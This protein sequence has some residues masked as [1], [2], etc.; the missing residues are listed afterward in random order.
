[1]DSKCNADCKFCVAALRYENRR[2][3]YQKPCLD[4]DAEYYAR[5]RK[6][7][8]IVKPLNLSVSVTGGEPTKSHRLPEILKII[9]EAGMRKRTIT[10]NGSGLADIYDG[11]SLLDHLIERKFDHL[12][13][14][15][16][17]Y[18]EAENQRI[19]R[20]DRPNELSF[21]T[22]NDDLRIFIPYALKHGLRPRMSCLLLAEGIRDVEGMEKYLD[23]Y[24]A[25][26]LDNAIF[27]ETMDYDTEAMINDEKKR[28]CE[29]NKV[30]LNDIWPQIDLVP[31]FEPFK[32]ILGYY[33]YVEIY[34]HGK[35]VV[36]SE[37]A[38]IRVQ[39]AEKARHPEVVYE[40]VFHPNGNLNGS[41]VDDEDILDPNQS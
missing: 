20:Y 17:H 39:Y 27:R 13:L 5:L 19:M 10:T 34:N 18:D 28:Y 4:N 24:A 1:V 29:E 36:C 9:D 40:M 16:V 15:R 25:M 11:K 2:R 32:N 22:S 30:R 8:A 38:D 31:E 21:Y 12:N 3:N 6:V 7:L 41:W 23:T 26:G 35:V 33:Y 37:S 14:S